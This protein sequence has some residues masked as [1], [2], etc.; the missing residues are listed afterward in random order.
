MQHKLQSFHALALTA[1]MLHFDLIS[2]AKT[3]TDICVLKTYSLVIRRV[4]R[5]GYAT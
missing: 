3:I 2:V 5:G 1:L 4:N